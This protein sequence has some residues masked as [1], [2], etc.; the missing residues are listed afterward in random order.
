M[1]IEIR[2]ASENDFNAIFEL[3]KEFA[4]FIKTPEKVTL[5]LEQMQ[6]DKDYFNSLIAT[7]NN[8]VIGFAT[9]FF[10]YYSWT[11]KTL[12]IDDLFIIQQ[13]R[14]KGIGTTLINS[15]INIAKQENCKKMRWQ[16]SNWNKPAIEFYKRLGAEIDGVE[17]NCLLNLTC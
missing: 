16:V 9:Y 15:L 10:A 14:G 11:G 5:T 2:K 13:Y 6:K 8:N 7:D 12:Y 17:Q 3:L 1:S 4:E